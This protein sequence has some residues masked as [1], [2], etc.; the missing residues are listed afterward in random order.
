MKSIL[1][2]CAVVVALWATPV[3]ANSVGFE[4]QGLVFGAATGGVIVAGSAVTGMTIGSTTFPGSGSLFIATG[5]LL[6]SLSDGGT[7]SSGVIGLNLGSISIFASN[8][9]G[10][11]TKLSDDIYELSGL[12]SGGGVGGLTLQLFQVQ[13]GDNGTCFRDVSGVTD[14]SS[15]PEPGTLTLLAT[16]LM[17]LAGAARRKLLSGAA[18]R[19]SVHNF[20]PINGIESGNS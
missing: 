9:T 16:G 7:F 15:V 4:N 13:F 3:F 18:L 11:W 1:A 2:I 12:F 20:A 5:T 6:G 17:G 10:S 14:I 8:F 19:L